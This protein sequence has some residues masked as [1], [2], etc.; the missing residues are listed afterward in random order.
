WPPSTPARPAGLVK[1]ASGDVAAVSARPRATERAPTGRTRTRQHSSAG[2]RSS[3]PR[4]CACP[5]AACVAAAR[6]STSATN[7]R[8]R[9]SRSPLR[10]IGCRRTSERLRLVQQHDRNVVPHFIPKPAR[11]ADQLLLLGPI[12]QLALALRANE[13]L[14]QL[15]IQHLSSSAHRDRSRSSLGTGYPRCRSA[16]RFFRHPG[17]AFTQRSRYTR[18]PM[19]ASIFSRDRCP[20]RRI[21]APPF[22]IRIA[23]WLSLSTN[24]TA[25]I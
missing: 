23:F 2:E 6:A 25:R 24:T 11:V 22:P 14:Q 15:R 12:L 8:F 18:S 4:I 5:G 21:P 7:P 13:D 16:E 1:T 19:N 10:W 17:I 3:I 20:R 9:L